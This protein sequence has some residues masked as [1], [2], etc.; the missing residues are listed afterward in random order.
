ML[1]EKQIAAMIDL[2]CVRTNNTKA[3]IEELVNGAKKYEIGQV[4]VLQSFVTYVKELLKGDPKIKL[5]GNVSFPAG[6]DSTSL[7]VIQTMELVASGCDEIDMVMNVGKFLSR[8][9][10]PCSGNPN[11][12]HYFRD[13]HLTTCFCGNQSGFEYLHDTHP[14]QEVG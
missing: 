1:T 13:N 12:L 4:A 11:R 7:K 10:S 2:S 8:S 9:S 14:V 6:S 3:E 5:S